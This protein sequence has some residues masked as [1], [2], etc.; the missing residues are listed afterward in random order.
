MRDASNLKAYLLWSLVTDARVRKRIEEIFGRLKTVAL[1]RKVR[2]RGTE[3][4]DWML[5]FTA[6]GL[7]EI[8]IADGSGQVS[9]SYATT[10]G[11]QNGTGHHFVVC[12]KGS[13]SPEAEA[14]FS[15][16]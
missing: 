7:D 8:K 6:A 1:M 9:W 2:H 15:V 14:A 13:L 16:P 3:R 12:T 4:F 10:P 5:V 11:T